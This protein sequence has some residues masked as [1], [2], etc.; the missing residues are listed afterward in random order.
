M[1]IYIETPISEGL[2]TDNSPHITDIGDMRYHEN[3]FWYINNS[4]ISGDGDCRY[5]YDPPTWWLKPIPLEEW[6]EE[7]SEWKHNNT[8][9]NSRNLNGYYLFISKEGKYERK[10]S[11]ELVTEFM[12]TKKYI[13]K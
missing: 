6:M 1:K 12:K 7:F 3:G 11:A 2:P 8:M 4:D 9:P 10:D 13:K 5:Q